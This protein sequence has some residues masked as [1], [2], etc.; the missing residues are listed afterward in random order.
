MTVQKRPMSSDGR[1]LERRK[2][3]R[4]PVTIPIEVSWIAEEIRRN[5]FQP[6][7]NSS[8]GCDRKWER[9]NNVKRTSVPGRRKGVA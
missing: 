8:F 5:E 4:F 1:K 7:K 6:S 2:S 3:C 9:F